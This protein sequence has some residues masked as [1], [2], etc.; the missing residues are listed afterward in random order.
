MIETPW[1]FIAFLAYI[2]IVAGIRLLKQT[3]KEV[4]ISEG[5]NGVDHLEEHNFLGV[6][7]CC[8]H[9]KG[10]LGSPTCCW[11]QPWLGRIHRLQLMGIRRKVQSW[12]PTWYVS[13]S[14][15][16]YNIDVLFFIELRTD[17]I[18]I[19]MYYFWDSFQVYIRAAQCC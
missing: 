2:Y 5:S 10:S 13:Q 16:S 17:S 19:D 9:D 12:R 6:A 8:L 14:Q 7:L 11:R 1:M 15:L 4:R 3:Q 18:I